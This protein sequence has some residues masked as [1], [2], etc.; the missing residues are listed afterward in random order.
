MSDWLSRNLTE[1]LQLPPSATDWLLSLWNAM[2]VFDDVADGD[3][4]SRPDLDRA[5]HD[6]FVGFYANQFFMA[7]AP[8][9][10]PLMA[11]AILKWQA[12]DKA[13]RDHAPTAMSYAWRAGYYDIVLAV[14]SLCHGQQVAKDNAHVVMG[15]YGETLEDYLAEFNHA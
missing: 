2:Q 3:Q 12:S 13:E 5:I 7:N 15:I 1:I 6:C 9:L 8:F 4:V 14:V 11:V 10:I